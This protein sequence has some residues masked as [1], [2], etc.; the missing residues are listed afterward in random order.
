MNKR[1]RNIRHALIKKKS[2]MKLVRI[3]IRNDNTAGIFCGSHAGSM[4]NRTVQVMV[5]FIFI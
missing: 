5:S 1:K 4:L 3:R 2:K